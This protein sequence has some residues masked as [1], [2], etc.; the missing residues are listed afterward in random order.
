MCSYVK[1]EEPQDQC[2][3]NIPS[4]MD[5]VF[6]I[7]MPHPSLGIN[8]GSDLVGNNTTAISDDTKYNFLGRI[9]DKKENGNL[10]LHLPPQIKTNRYV[11][12]ERPYVEE[13]WR[14][15]ANGRMTN[16]NKG[17]NR[18]SVSQMDTTL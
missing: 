6:S 17:S 3:H 9:V 13:K 12:L 15:V 8:D 18:R 10:P 11:A 5:W 4:D 7:C 1:N 2:A 14:I 16:Q